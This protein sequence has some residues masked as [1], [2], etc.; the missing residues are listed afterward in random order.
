M[1]IREVLLVCVGNICRSPMAE[2]L[3]RQALKN[4]PDIC[5]SSAGIAAL[6]GEP[7]DEHA[8]ALMQD[9]GLDVSGHRARQ[10]NEELID[11]ANLILVM[12]TG[13]K[14]AI[15]LQDPAARGKVHRLCEAQRKDIP[16]PYR[17]PREA[18]EDALVLIEA[19]V[20]DWA[21]KIL[22]SEARSA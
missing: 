2:A 7:A 4:R 11:T 21:G 3:M 6:V 9:R 13:H 17:R 19:G 12:E 8:V 14:R 22:R 10:L 18:F 20:Q 16:D 5:V 1:I 15:D